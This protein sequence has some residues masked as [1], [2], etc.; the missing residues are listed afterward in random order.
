MIEKSGHSSTTKD[1]FRRGMIAGILT[2]LLMGLADTYGYATTGYTTAELSILVSPVIVRLILGKEAS[3]TELVVGSVAAYG[4][5]FATIITSGMLITNAYTWFVYTYIFHG[6]DFP[7][8]L[9]NPES[10][11]LKIFCPYTTTYVY[12]GLLSLSGVVLAYIYR[13]VFVDKMNLPYPLSITSFM[14]SGFLSRIKTFREVF[15]IMMIGLVSQYLIFYTGTPSIDLSPSLNIFIKGSVF[16]ISI[17][18][19]MLS[20]A[21]ILPVRASI[22]ISLSSILT[23]LLILPLGAYLSFYSIGRDTSIDNIIF[24]SSWYLASVIFGSVMILGITYLYKMKDIIIILFKILRQSEERL[25]TII[26]YIGFLSLFL[27]TIPYVESIDI[28]YIIFS[29][30]WVLILLPMLIIL[31]TIAI[32][33]AGIAAQS[34]YPFNTVYLYLTGFRGFAPYVFMDHYLGI[35]MPGSLSGASTNV[36]KLSRMSGINVVRLLMIFTT[37]FI[38]GLLITMFYGI[39]LIKIF[40]FESSSFSLLRWLPYVN[41]SIMIYKGQLDLS[42]I[43]GGVVIGALYMIFILALGA[44]TPIKISPIPFIIGIS[45][46]P[47]YGILFAIGSFIRWYISNFGVEAQE[48]LVIYSIA[49]LVGCGLSI[50]TYILTSILSG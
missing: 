46:T 7:K 48:R 42:T 23:S 43:G 20:L 9:Y 2:G 38:L 4:M 15:I 29:I 22:S 6:T 50:P 10:C 36:I 8:W 33:E 12:G 27:A 39:S 14:T 17:S 5:S 35:P 21:I 26:M 41:W 32:G 13:H 40:G 19:I 34:L 18:F 30:I 37:S 1:P 45:L 31:T 24:R 28:R 11:F 49:F 47:D 25:L 3:L 44:L 16:N